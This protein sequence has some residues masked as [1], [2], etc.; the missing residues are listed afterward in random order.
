LGRHLGAGLGAGLGRGDG[1]A[2]LL[3]VVL[4]PEAGVVG[5]VGADDVAAV[6]LE[7]GPRLEVRLDVELVR[8]LGEGGKGKRKKEKGKS[9]EEAHPDTAYRDPRVFHS[10]PLVP[11][12]WIQSPQTSSRTSSET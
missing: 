1:L 4:Q 3:E 2:V 11:L 10:S 6:E 7:G 12:R 8:R 9:D 5:D